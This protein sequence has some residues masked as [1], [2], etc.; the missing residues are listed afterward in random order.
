M[1]ILVT[2]GAGFIGSHIVDA[3]IDAG[4]AVAIIDNFIS[5]Q[6]ENVNPRASLFELDIRD[7][8]LEEVFKSFLPDILIHQA[9]Q[10]D[11]RASVA[12]PA[13][14][15]DVNIIGSLRLL[16]NCIRNNV[17][18]VVFASTGG[19]IYVEQDYFPADENHPE[20]PISPYG[21]AKLS[22]EKY[23]YYYQVVH[24][25]P[26][27]ALR[28]SNVYGP[29][30]N[31]HGEAGVVA[32]FAERMFSGKTVVING[33]GN[34]TRDYVFVE[35]VVH[36]NLLAMESEFSG[37]LNIGTG[38]ETDVNTLFSILRDQIDPSIDPV[39]GEEKKG[40]Q[41]RSV[42]DSKKAQEILG[43]KPKSELIEGL[44]KTADFFR[45]HC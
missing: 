15:A 9:A 27:I 5:G 37:S 42:V 8:K 25:L 7:S 18:K 38:I 6:R 4:H 33:N 39:N 22:V 24:N 16:E 17:G 14:D 34:Q 2:G 45:T 35:D 21:I 19:A 12:D 32:I 10:L 11:V 23:L 13:F 31:P 43:W 30:Q 26:F 41:L 1:K 44:A 29:R 3:L 28:Y 36:A 20:R 40:E